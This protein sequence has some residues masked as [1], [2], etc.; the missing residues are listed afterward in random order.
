MHELLG[1]EALLLRRAHALKVATLVI[2]EELQVDTHRGR[3]FREVERARKLMRLREVGERAALAEIA[4]ADS[5][6]AS[7]V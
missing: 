1:S 5:C 7:G 2:L 4:W 6:R 3:S